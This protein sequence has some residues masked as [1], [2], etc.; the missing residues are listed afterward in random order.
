M[1]VERQSQYAETAQYAMTPLEEA[2]RQTE[3]L[4]VYERPKWVFQQAYGSGAEPLR[5]LAA[6][7]RVGRFVSRPDQRP[8][9]CP[10]RRRWWA[11]WPA[12]ERRR[13]P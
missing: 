8:L 6:E 11:P 7:I 12:R 10:M 9:P 5:R 3:A 13:R 2:G 4:S 1:W